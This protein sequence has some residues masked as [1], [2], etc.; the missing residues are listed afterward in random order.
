[1]LEAYHIGDG[2]KSVF[3]KVLIRNRCEKLIKTSKGELLFDGKKLQAHQNCESRFN[4]TEIKPNDELRIS[5][6]YN[7]PHYQDDM[8]EW[9]KTHSNKKFRFQFQDENTGK[10]FKSKRV[11]VKDIPIN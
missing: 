2:E 11:K 5:F 8:N 1:M 6:G 4:N 9:K 3:I 10:E 7:L